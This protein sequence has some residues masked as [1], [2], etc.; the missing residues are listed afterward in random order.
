MNLYKVYTLGNLIFDGWGKLKLDIFWVRK[1]RAQSR[2]YFHSFWIKWRKTRRKY[3]NRFYLKIS[4]T[5][6]RWTVNRKLISRPLREGFQSHVN[7][8]KDG[9]RKTKVIFKACK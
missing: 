5:I 9:S 8:R 6:S 1:K 4:P 3:W 2:L 7:G